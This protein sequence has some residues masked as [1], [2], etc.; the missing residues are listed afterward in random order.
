[1]NDS[2]PDTR[3]RTAAFV[4]HILAVITI[5]GFMFAVAAAAW[6]IAL[7]LVIPS[8]ITISA[9]WWCDDEYHRAVLEADD[10]RHGVVR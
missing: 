3:L 6:P 2:R 1:M 7:G 4:W 10:A 9:G 8:L 5:F